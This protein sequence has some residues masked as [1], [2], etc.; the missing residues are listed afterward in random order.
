MRLLAAGALRLD[1]QSPRV[2][3]E[4]IDALARMLA[5]EQIAVVAPVDVH[6]PDA[7]ADAHLALAA[8][9]RVPLLFYAGPASS[10][11]V[12]ARALKRA[13]ALG[14][15]PRR[16]AVGGIDHLAIR[17][18]LDAGALGVLGV[19]SGALGPR[20]VLDVV[21]RFDDA[22]WPHLA[23]GSAV[24]G[25]G[26][27]DVLSLPRAAEA[28]AGADLPTSAAAAVTWRNAHRWLGLPASP[29]AIEL[30]ELR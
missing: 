6:R 16:I 23:L 19:G 22:A 7:L 9:L 20:D 12:V 3:D 17:P 29:A 8:E 11:T 13:I 10:P 4:A 27:T 30:N 24:H 21:A 25:G 14:I 15:E 5:A 26:A 1:S 28:L 2:L 18:V